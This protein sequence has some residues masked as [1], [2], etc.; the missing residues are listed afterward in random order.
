M[1]TGTTEKLHIFYCNLNG[2]CQSILFGGR[3]FSADEENN[4]HE[5]YV[6]CIR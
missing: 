4:K 1:S 5:G 6:G 3:N 2:V